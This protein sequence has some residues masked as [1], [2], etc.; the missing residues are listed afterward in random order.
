MILEDVKTNYDPGPGRLRIFV[1]TDGG[2][3]DSPPPYHGMQGMDPL[4][5]EL[6]DDGYNIEFHVVFVTGIIE[7]AAAI[8]FGHERLSQRDVNRYRDLAQATGGGFMHASLDSDPDER[9]AFLSRIERDSAP[10]R[11]EAQ[12]AYERR[13]HR[14]DATDFDWYRRLSK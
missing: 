7:D 4:M 3:T 12:Q 8:A 9:E 13:L 11:I 2:D 5:Q 10:L 6:Q 14:G 1:V